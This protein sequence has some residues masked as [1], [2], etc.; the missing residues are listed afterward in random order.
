MRCKLRVERIA[1]EIRSSDSDCALDLGNKTLLVAARERL[2]AIAR[3]ADRYAI[4]SRPGRGTAMMARFFQPGHPLFPGRS[5]VS[6]SI[7]NPCES[8]C[9]DDWATGHD[10]S[11][12]TLLVVDGSG[13]GPLA[14]QAAEI[15]ARTFRDNL[16]HDCVPLVE[17]IHRA[18][19]STRGA[20]FAVGTHR[21]C[22]PSR[23]VCWSEQ[24]RRGARGR[25]PVSPNGIQ[26]R[27]RLA[28]RAAHSRVHVSL[29][30]KAAGPDLGNSPSA[31]ALAARSGGAD[32][33]KPTFPRSR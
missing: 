2:G 12:V 22:R 6:S 23:T 33:E 17:T 16:D 9:G 24:Y 7:P 26:Q 31:G 21:R 15:A 28:Y 25:R 5:L 10:P 30:R 32:L 20:A 1:G 8:V 13:H 19:A 14:A 4:Y 11:S 3:N 18:L 29:H 27:H